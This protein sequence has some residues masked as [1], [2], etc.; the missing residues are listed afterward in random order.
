MQDSSHIKS[1]T[2]SVLLHR[3]VDPLSELITVF[4]LLATVLSAVLAHAM[5][6]I[7]ADTALDTPDVSVERE[8]DIPQSVVKFDVPIQR[9]EGGERRN[10]IEHCSAYAVYK[11]AKH[12]SFLS[13][14]HCVDGYQRTRNAPILKHVGS[15]TKPTLLES[16]GSMEQDWLLMTVPE[17]A[18]DETLTF[19]PLAQEPVKLGEVLYGF[20]WGG[21]AQTSLSSPKALICRVKA[22]GLKLALDCG[23]AK[24][25]SGGLIARRVNGK[26]EAVGIISAGDAST[27]TYAYPISV[28]P[29]SISSQI[30]TRTD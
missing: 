6:D 18:F 23:F 7:A 30:V 22:V 15:I 2:K 3:C 14:W 1:S 21:H 4:I 12:Y 5:P 19:T 26:Y 17:Q 27:I 9:V 10:F 20:G 28:L 13:S 8:I 29:R 11:T 24:G 16:G 25:D